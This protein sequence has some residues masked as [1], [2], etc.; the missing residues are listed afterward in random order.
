MSA[1]ASA[2]P[3][4]G[5]SWRSVFIFPSAVPFSL[6]P[7]SGMVPVIVPLK[8]CAAAVVYAGHTDQDGGG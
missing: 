3:L 4:T 6:A 1:E 8:C 7:S 2:K 5:F